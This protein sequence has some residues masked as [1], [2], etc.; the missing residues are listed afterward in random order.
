MRSLFLGLLFLIL[1]G[2]AGYASFQRWG[3]KKVNA[4]ETGAAQSRP[5][6]GP[7]P[8]TQNASQNATNTAVVRPAGSAGDA[9][10]ANAD[11]TKIAP[12]S[13]A[14]RMEQAISLA[15]AAEASSDLPGQARALTTAL[16]AALSM[17]GKP[18]W[19]RAEP[20]AA[21]LAATNEKLWFNPDATFRSTTEKP[22]ALAK[23][24]SQ[25]AKKDPP[26]RVGTGLLARMNKLSDPDIVPGHKRLRVPQDSMSIT[27]RRG[28]FSLILYLGGYAI[29]AFPVGVGKPSSPSPVGS[30]EI[31]EIQ[32][33][34]KYKREAT[35]WIRPDDGKELYYGDAEY[36][37]GKR[38]LK[39]G[40]PVEHYGIHGT[41]RD[42][43]IGAAISHGCIRMLNRDVERLAGFLDAAGSPRIVVRIE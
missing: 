40:E 4:E 1:A 26:V 18:A 11:I 17:E 38:F 36:P 14:D 19:T 10:A 33:L 2:V 5:L 6:T 20:I 42:D 30:F 34:D 35:K 41:D 12:A 13:A 43:A 3:G 24:I 15:A 29:E 25:L 23:I 28:S 37:F 32:H 9:S 8:S 22:V 39:F 7:A 27:V 21:A 31:R 16:E